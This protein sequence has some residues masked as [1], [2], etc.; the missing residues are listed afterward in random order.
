MNIR[1]P[2]MKLDPAMLKRL[3]ELRK[4]K[5]KKKTA[6]KRK[7][8]PRK[9]VARKVPVS[10]RSVRKAPV[11]KAPVSKAPA[12][13]KPVIAKAPTRPTRRSEPP[14]ASVRKRT[15]VRKPSPPKAPK[16]TIEPLVIDV[17]ENAMGAPSVPAPTRKKIPEKKTVARKASR[18]K[19]KPKPKQKPTNN[20][21]PA[22]QPIRKPVA[23]KKPTPTSARK[24]NI[25]K[26]KDLVEMA[27]DPKLGQGRAGIAKAVEE[28]IKGTAKIPAESVG[29]VPD[30]YAGRT[31]HGNFADMAGKGTV[32]DDY[33][34]VSK[35]TA[36]QIPATQ[37]QTGGS[38][39]AAYIDWMESEPTPPRRPK[40]MGA[41]S[42]KYQK[43]N[44]DYKKNL[45]EWRASKPSRASFVA[46]APVTTQPTE[47]TP[48][49]TMP[50]QPRMINMDPLAGMRESF[51]PRNILGQT[52]NPADREAYEAS[53]QQQREQM[54]PGGNIQSG[55]YPV[56]M[57]PLSAVPQV[58]FG[59]YGAQMPM[60]ALAPYAGMGGVSSPEQ[61][62]PN[63][64]PH[65]MPKPDPIIE[66]VERPATPSPRP[67]TGPVMSSDIPGAIPGQTPGVDFDVFENPM[68]GY[69]R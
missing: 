12:V 43:A 16:T 61:R 4:S 59:G 41:A 20:F 60:T 28:A 37:Q 52:Y 50:P 1:I 21:K 19:Q 36:P 49:V 13:I 14:K 29:T 64:F 34:Y 31:V 8:T 65:Y 5:P 24:I 67:Y 58:Q 3:A 54:T 63:F 42:K 9:A 11:R 53:V 38:F 69:V 6:S 55:G 2:E 46:S 22:V 23:P 25:E 18:P 10:T 27:K 33:N 45:S 26:I 47:P 32:P 44:R 7:T 68:G 56:A 17:V 39:E 15:P 62:P 48:P 66:T 57:N 51:V 40:G 35:P 30:D